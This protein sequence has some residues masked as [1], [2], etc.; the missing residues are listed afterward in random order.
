[1]ARVIRRRYLGGAAA[2]L[3][4]LLAAACGE[5]EVRYVQGPAGPA[6]PAGSQGERGTAGAAGSKGAVGAVGQSQVVVQEKVVTVEKPV[7]VEKVVEK[8]VEIEVPAQAAPPRRVVIWT[9]FWRGGNMSER[10]VGWLDLA[11][12]WNAQGTNITFNLEPVSGQG[13]NTTAKV[14]ANYA[15]GTHPD[16]HHH[17][18]RWTL[19]WGVQGMAVELSDFVKQDK[20]Y[21]ANMDDFY[22]HLLSSCMW[23]GN[24]WSVPNETNADLPYTN[25]GIVREAGLEP[26]KAGFT[27]DDWAD[28]LKAIQ[29]HLGPGKQSGKWAIGGMASWVQM[30]NLLKQA[31]GEIFNEDRMKS[32]FNSPA[33]IEAG[34]YFSDLVHKHQVHTPHGDYFKASGQEPPAFRRGTIAKFYETSAYRIVQWAQDIGGLENMYITPAPT[35]KQSFTGT[36]GS[37]DVMFKTNTEQQEAAWQVLRWI[38]STEPAAHYTKVIH[39]LPARRSILQVPE[40]QQILKDVPQFQTFVDTLEHAYRPTHPEFGQYIG[41]INNTMRGIQKE[42]RAVKDDLDQLVRTINAKMD[43]FE[44]RTA[45]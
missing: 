11:N 1:M 32:T 12:R 26:L 25:L 34:Q 4:G 18:F 33:G 42:P 24:L 15:A 40:Y 28:Y 22:P 23:R 6:G 16:L 2:A 3:G 29:A 17:S 13:A 36:F 37:N 43:D 9:L 8:R 41:D 45:G 38:T 21:S 27:W 7:I 10:G 44:K 35:K 19:G 14:I 5:I 20:E 39:F 30:V 31:G